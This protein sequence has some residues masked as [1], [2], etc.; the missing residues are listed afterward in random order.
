MWDNLRLSKASGFKWH[1]V[2]PPPGKRPRS[3]CPGSPR[4]SYSGS[5]PRAANSREQEE[6][7]PQGAHG[8]AHHLTAKKQPGFPKCPSTSLCM[9][10][11]CPPK[12]SVPSWLAQQLLGHMSPSVTPLASPVHSSSPPKKASPISLEGD[13][14]LSRSTWS[15]G[16]PMPVPDPNASLLQLLPLSELL[17]V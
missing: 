6:A 1:E 4:S 9:T 12:P 7:L 14:S 8:F 11:R 13:C 16:S 10:P 3:R 2:S 15:L 5:P 17:R